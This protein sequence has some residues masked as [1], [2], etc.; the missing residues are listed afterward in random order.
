MSVFSESNECDVCSIEDEE[1]VTDASECMEESQQEIIGCPGFALCID[2][3][4]MNIRRS[5]QR[6][7]RTTQSLHFCHGYAVQNR[8]NS[9][10]LANRPPSGVLSSDLILP[11]EADRNCILDDF[12]VLVSR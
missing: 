5:N 9:T 1:V 6:F 2:N 12:T 7:G 10:K 3:I 4:D 8:V 11:N